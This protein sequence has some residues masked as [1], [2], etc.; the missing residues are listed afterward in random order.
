M[1][2]FWTN[3]DYAMTFDDDGDLMKFELH[4]LLKAPSR[5]VIKKIAERSGY[6]ANKSFEIVPSKWTG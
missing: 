6:S 5:E 2:S 3:G 1:G 4:N